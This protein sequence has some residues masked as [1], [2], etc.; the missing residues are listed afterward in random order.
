MNGFQGM[1]V[2]AVRILAGH[3]SGRADDIDSLAASLSTELAHVQW[4]GDDADGFRHD[5]ET[6]YKVQL[7][8]ISVA[9][10]DAG[11][12]A[13]FNATQQQDASTR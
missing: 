2:G 1:D 11:S 3:L 13:T 8:N 6:T 12:R 5:W 9:L 4:I 10:R 7:H